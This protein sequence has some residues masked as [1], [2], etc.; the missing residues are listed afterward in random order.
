MSTPVLVGIGSNLHR[1][2]GLRA[3]L[4]ALSGWFEELVLSPVYESPAV[5][6]E[7]SP[8]LNM[9]VGFETCLPL[10][11]LSRRFKKLEADHGRL[12]GSPRYAP[13]ALDIDLLTFGE[14]VGVFCGIE[15]PRPEILINA[16]VLKPLAD[17]AG[18][19]LHPECGHSYQQLWQLHRTGQP[20]Q[21]V[22]FSWRGRVISTAV[23]RAK[24]GNQGIG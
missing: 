23:G 19:R 3:A 20:L 1:E 8:F 11:E 21:R 22:D 2:A 10:T 14:K 7:G 17:V 4:D 24:A 13:Q 6:F 5:G 9:V 12:P 16:H 18:A 15:L